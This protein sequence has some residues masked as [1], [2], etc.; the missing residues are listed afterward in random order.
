MPNQGNLPS[1]DELR[2]FFSRISKATPRFRPYY[3]NDIPNLDRLYQSTDN[4]TSNQFLNYFLGYLNEV[5]SR[6][7]K[8]EDNVTHF[9]TTCN[10]YLGTYD[11]S[12]DFNIVRRYRSPSVDHKELI[13]DRSDMTVSVKSTVSNKDIPIE[14]LSSGEKQMISLFGK[15]LLYDKPN[16][17]TCGI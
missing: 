16:T 8:I 5:I 6:V 7:S 15:M 9:I 13:L 1:Q 12:T 10:K 4:T 17:E 14:S 11:P 3:A 2:I